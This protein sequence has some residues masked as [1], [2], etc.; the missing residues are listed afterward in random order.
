MRTNFTKKEEYKRRFVLIWSLLVFYVFTFSVSAQNEPMQGTLEQDHKRFIEEGENRT[1]K[2]IMETMNREALAS[3]GRFLLKVTVVDESGQMLDG[4]SVHLRKVTALP[5]SEKDFKKMGSMENTT[6]GQKTIEETRIVNST[7]QFDIRESC[8]VKLTFNLNGY[9]REK[10][11][12]RTKLP[13]EHKERIGLEV[14]IEDY[15]DRLNSMKDLSQ[16]YK[17][18]FREDI[19]K[20]MKERLKDLPAVSEPE[21]TEN[22]L[23]VI[24]ERQGK[25]T[26]LIEYNRGPLEYT[27]SGKGIVINFDKHP[28]SSLRVIENIDNPKQLPEN[29]V[30]M[31]PEKDRDGNIA[32]VTKFNEKLTEAQKKNIPERWQKYVIPKRVRLVMN[33]GGGGFIKYTLDPNKKPTRQMKE[34]P[35]TGYEKEIVIE[36][37]DIYEG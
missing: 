19:I 30:Y 35:E 25:I 12:F 10:I 6:S 33:A 1:A 24:L 13:P 5:M 29:C 22:N 17:D 9:Y 14:E 11:E 7:F 20:P 28:A 26:H 3:N 23:H 31:I 4:V 32:V 16:E 18:R 27:T 36:S 8:Y 37:D 34:A 2:V 21:V 15:E